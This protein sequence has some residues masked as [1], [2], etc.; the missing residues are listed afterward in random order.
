MVLVGSNPSGW[1]ALV[2][3]VDDWA[4]AAGVNGLAQ[5]G[6]S[7]YRPRHLRAERFI[8]NHRLEELLHTTD[9]VVSH[10]GIGSIGD[11]L[12]HAR[13]FVI[14]PR[15]AV[16]V[17]DQIPVARRLAE[18]YAFPLADLSSLPECAS[19]LLEEPERCPESPETDVP[20]LI[21]RFLLARRQE[22]VRPWT[23]GLA[24]GRP[25][26]PSQEEDPGS[27]R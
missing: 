27:V 5:V 3:R 17:G 12:R 23:R 18:R 26:R 20:D 10:G 1:D 8:E 6:G 24:L 11:C 16:W 9:L 19:K 2:K 7:S 25:S 21:R 15:S 13:R 4:G 14:V 22:A